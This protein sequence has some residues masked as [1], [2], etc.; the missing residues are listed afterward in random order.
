[1]KETDRRIKEADRRMEKLRESQEENARQMKETDR[2]MEETARQ[3][4]ETDRQLK[5]TDGKISKLGNR[6][7]E[8]VEYMVMPN[9]I[10]KF[11]ELGFVF[12]KVYPEASIKDRQNQILAEIDL[13]LENGDKVMI[14]EVKTKPSIKDIAEHVE[15]MQKVRMHAD[16]HGDKRKFLGAVAGMVIKENV[17][18]FAL[19]TGF[20]MIE[21]S[22]DTFNI[23]E[24][25]GKYRPHEW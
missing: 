14:V 24:P 8:M 5:E 17:R 3:M 1:M 10:D 18:E 21:P 13:T 15:R 4:K 6:F 20:Y 16:L 22:G 23:I 12:T 19:K 9:L 25:K 2:R 11:H 7:G